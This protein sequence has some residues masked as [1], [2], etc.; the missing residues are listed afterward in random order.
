MMK[1]SS[2]L[3]LRSSISNWCVC[4]WMCFLCYIFYW[5]FTYTNSQA[6]TIQI[7]ELSLA[8]IRI[9]EE[10]ENFP[11][12]CFD[13]ILCTVHIQCWDQAPSIPKHIF[14]LRLELCIN[15]EQFQLFWHMK[16]TME[17][18]ILLPRNVVCIFGH[19]T[20]LIAVK[21]INKLFRCVEETKMQHLYRCIT[22]CLQSQ[23]GQVICFDKIKESAWRP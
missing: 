6:N 8:C 12:I 15:F 18:S 21:T 14:Q 7:M 1:T 11:H 20:S 13:I 17:N 4:V 19:S 22:D 16:Y 2:V 10:N 23:D 3:K 9:N 5:W